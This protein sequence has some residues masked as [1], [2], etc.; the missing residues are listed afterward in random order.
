VRNSSPA[1]WVSPENGGRLSGY[2]EPQPFGLRFIV[3]PRMSKRVRG[4]G[5]R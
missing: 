2:T 3:A 5:N 1:E 4:S